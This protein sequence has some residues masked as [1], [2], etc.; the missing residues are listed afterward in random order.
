MP[1]R[2]WIEAP[3]FTLVLM[4][5][6]LGITSDAGALRVLGAMGLGVFVGRVIA[7]LV[8]LEETR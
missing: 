2:L 7:T 4:F 1:K 5:S 8:R 3:L 6:I